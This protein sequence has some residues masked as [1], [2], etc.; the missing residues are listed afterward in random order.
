M[1]SRDASRPR[2]VAVAADAG[3]GNGLRSE[4]APPAK[5][6]DTQVPIGLLMSAAMR[7]HYVDIERR[8]LEQ[9]YDDLR[10]S[11]TVVFENITADGARVS[12]IARLSMVTKQAVAQT[13]AYLEERG[14][15]ERRPDPDD[16]RAKIVTLSRKGRR[17][18]T[19]AKLLLIDMEEELDRQLGEE[20]LMCVRRAL[21]L[22][23]SPTATPE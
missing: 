8:L 10:H 23:A 20:C 17:A 18:A 7:S 12:D 16:A 9:G 13:V 5:D 1:S 15:V 2:A 14:Y 4:P 21:N 22:I 19:V 6:G 3:N 11:D